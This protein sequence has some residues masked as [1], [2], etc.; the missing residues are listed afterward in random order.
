M[1][2]ERRDLHGR[3]GIIYEP[4]NIFFFCLEETNHAN[5]VDSLFNIHEYPV[6][7]FGGISRLFLIDM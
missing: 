7:S 3:R 5:T 6:L 2:E 1:G 4:F